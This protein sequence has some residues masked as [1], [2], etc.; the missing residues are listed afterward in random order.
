MS[1]VE[2]LLESG[3]DDYLGFEEGFKVLQ[4]ISPF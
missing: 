4:D 2:N 1:L 3:L